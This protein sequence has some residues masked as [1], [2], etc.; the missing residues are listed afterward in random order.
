M[1]WQRKVGYDWKMQQFISNKNESINFNKKLPAFLF[2][3]NDRHI[4][5]IADDDMM[6]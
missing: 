1:L 2:D 5:L 6:Q 4:Y 3:F